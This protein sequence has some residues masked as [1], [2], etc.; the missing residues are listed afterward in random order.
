MC[1]NSRE[2]TLDSLMDDT[3]RDTRTVLSSPKTVQWTLVRPPFG[4]NSE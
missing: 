4:L 3:K 2:K 1:L